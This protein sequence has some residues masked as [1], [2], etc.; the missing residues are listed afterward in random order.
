MSA[1]MLFTAYVD[2]EEMARV[3]NA[4]LRELCAVHDVSAEIR[5]VDVG[6]EP[7]VA[8]ESNVVGVPTVVRESPRPRRRVIG[9][10]DDT[11]RV[12][13]ALGLNAYDGDGGRA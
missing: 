2:G 9:S 3:V 4:R 1:Q 7:G 12:A 10:L 11:R 13:D 8:E 5:L 6:A